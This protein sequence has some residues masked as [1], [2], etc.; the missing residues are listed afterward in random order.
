MPSRSSSPERS[1]SKPKLSS[2]HAR[3]YPMATSGA[4][5]PRSC[6]IAKN[7]KP[8][9]STTIPIAIPSATSDPDSLDLA[10]EIEILG[11]QAAG[12]VRGERH[13]HPLPAHVEIRVVISALGEETDPHHERD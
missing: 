13:S 10:R 8:R 9:S 11:G 5:G 3:S 4:P 1:H 6:A 2:S 12:V 7:K